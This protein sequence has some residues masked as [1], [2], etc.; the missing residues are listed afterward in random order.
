MAIAK[1]V[2]AMVSPGEQVLKLVRIALSRTLK[3]EIIM[4]QDGAREF[5]VC[6]SSEYCKHPL[7]LKVCRVVA[8]HHLRY[9]DA[10]ADEYFYAVARAFKS[11]GAS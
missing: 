1:G 9:S 11:Q 8:A 6:M 4:R 10:G 5:V 2:P 3:N 7:T